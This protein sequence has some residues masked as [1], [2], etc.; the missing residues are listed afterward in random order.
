MDAEHKTK[1]EQKIFAVLLVVFLIILVTG[2]LKQLGFFRRAA[3]P[4]STT[5]SLHGD[6]KMSQSLQ[7][8]VQEYQKKMDQEVTSLQDTP[9][10]EVASPSVVN[11]TAQDLRDPLKSLLPPVPSPRTE[12]R[13]TDASAP[14]VAQSPKPSPA[15]LQ[16][17]GLFWGGTQPQA[18]INHRVYRVGESVEGAKIVTID[19]AGVT[20]DHQGS[21]L[22]YPAPSSKS[23][24]TAGKPE[25]ATG[26]QEIMAAPTPPP[27]VPSEWAGTGDSGQATGYYESAPESSM[28]SMPT[29]TM[30]SGF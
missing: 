11:Y 2:P 21:T 20:L 9:Q 30:G 24:Q 26:P 10:P 3:A 7:V 15:V 29:E 16:I 6:V 19:R 17:Q 8:S 4:R 22:V 23:E 1:A 12:L 18:I 28:S 14:V 13:S 27:N 5:T 25:E